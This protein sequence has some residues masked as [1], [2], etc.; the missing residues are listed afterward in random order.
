MCL[1]EIWQELN[2]FQDSSFV[3][4]GVTNILGMIMP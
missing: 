4:E 3:A 2:P 1:A